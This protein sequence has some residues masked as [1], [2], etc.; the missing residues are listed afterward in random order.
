MIYT[1]KLKIFN[2]SKGELLAIEYKNFK[3]FKIRRSFFINFKSKNTIR[4]KHAHKK[5]SQFL[6]CTSGKIK[7][8]SIDAKGNKK[9]F[10]LSNMKIGL[11]IKPLVW[12]ELVSLKKN[13]T[14]V[15]LADYNYDPSDYINKIEDIK[16]FK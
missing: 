10:I 12:L 2:N 11:L 13:S 14:L 3:Y 4:G 8:K 15:C 5:C 7:I 9:N 16:N 1:K 6:F